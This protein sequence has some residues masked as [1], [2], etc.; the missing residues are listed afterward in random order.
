MY[1]FNLTW[2]LCIIIMR[3]N[4]NLVWCGCV[5]SSDDENANFQGETPCCYINL[6]Q[7]QI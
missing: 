6:L 4:S 7:T 2:F 5:R 3:G 1:D